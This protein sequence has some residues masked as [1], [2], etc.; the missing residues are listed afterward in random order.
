MEAGSP[1]FWG[2]LGLCWVWGCVVVELGCF[3]EPSPGR[4]GEAGGGILAP[5]VAVRREAACE[6]RPRSVVTESIRAGAGSLGPQGGKSEGFLP[7]SHPH[8]TFLGYK[9]S[10]RPG[11]GL[12]RHRRGV[13]ESFGEV[14]A[15][16]GLWLCWQSD[17]EFNN[18]N[19]NKICFLLRPEVSVLG[20]VSGVCAG[21][22]PQP[23]FCSRSLF[24]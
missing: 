23:A 8:A 11:L 14:E 3:G 4:K 17:T 21:A 19:N 12:I 6:G 24:P 2:V 16:E 1:L 5:A 15:R 18:N 20:W 22:A 9:W 7:Q 13:L 10:E